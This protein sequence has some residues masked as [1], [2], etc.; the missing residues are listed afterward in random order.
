MEQTATLVG[1]KRCHGPLN[2]GDHILN[3][4]D[5][6]YSGKII[7]VL[8]LSAVSLL[9]WYAKKTIFWSGIEIGLVLYGKGVCFVVYSPINS[10]SLFIWLRPIRSNRIY[11]TYESA[12]FIM[13]DLEK[14]YLELNFC[15][16]SICSY[17]WQGRLR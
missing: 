1:S 7:S 15:L 11:F 16:Q 12:K 6:I 14:L 3:S 2:S 5:K 10:K 8:S 17:F 9:R 13:D 4:R